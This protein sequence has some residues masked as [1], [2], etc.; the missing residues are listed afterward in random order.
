MPHEIKIDFATDL[1]GTKLIWDLLYYIKYEYIK[2]GGENSSRLFC[3]DSCKYY[4]LLY[5]YTDL[6]CVHIHIVFSLWKLCFQ[7]EKKILELNCT[8]RFKI[9]HELWNLSIFQSVENWNL[10]EHR[11]IHYLKYRL[12]QLSSLFWYVPRLHLSRI[13]YLSC[14]LFLDVDI[15]KCMR[16]LLSE[17]SWDKKMVSVEWIK[18]F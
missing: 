3:K 17:T 5:M 1:S 14:H 2:S 18:N 16:K 11:F 7:G 8:V 4:V 10:C 12:L 6:F 15:P 13:A 9:K